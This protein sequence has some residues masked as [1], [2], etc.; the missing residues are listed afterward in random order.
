MKVLIED[1]Q[2]SKDVLLVIKSV[3]DGFGGPKYVT[4]IRIVKRGKQRLSMQSILVVELKNPEMKESVEINSH[5]FKSL[6]YE[7][8]CM[9]CLKELMEYCGID[10]RKSD[11]QPKETVWK[12][13]K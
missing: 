3:I 10:S 11:F 5:F 12:K 9:G 2:T 6:F 13:N 7:N 8:G 4:S 1:E